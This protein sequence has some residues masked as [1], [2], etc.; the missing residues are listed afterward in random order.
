MFKIVFYACSRLLQNKTY[1][2]HYFEFL[3]NF[4]NQVLYYF[5]YF[6]QL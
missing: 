5:E 3:L 1:M 6:A 4:K 2:L